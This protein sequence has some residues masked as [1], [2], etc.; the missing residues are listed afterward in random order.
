MKKIIKLAVIRE[1]EENGCPFGLCIPDACKTVGSLIDQM[2]PISADMDDAEKE[3][4]TQANN[5]ILMFDQSQQSGKC[6]YANALFKKKVECNFGDF[7]AGKGHLDTTGSPMIGSYLGGSFYSVPLGFY[8]QSLIDVWDNFMKRT[9]AD[10]ESA[11]IIK[12]S[13]EENK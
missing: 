5:R 10:D 2:V 1:N 12:S 11:D 8:N 3:T 9:F 4:I 6:K 13:S 7:A